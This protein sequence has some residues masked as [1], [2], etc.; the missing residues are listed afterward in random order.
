MQL[1]E[2]QLIYIHTNTH[3]HTHACCIGVQYYYDQDTQSAI[4]YLTK[5]SGDGWT[6]AGTWFTFN[7]KTSI[8]A[9]TKY[10]S[11]HNISIISCT[12][13]YL[14]PIEDKELAGAFVFDTSQDTVTDSGEFTYELTNALYSGLQDSSTSDVLCDSSQD[15]K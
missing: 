13:K 3:T 5:D 7:D 11:K 12:I 1:H 14:S 6:K 8:E 2:L 9:L 4:G 10:I 15:C